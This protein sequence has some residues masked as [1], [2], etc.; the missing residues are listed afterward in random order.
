[1]GTHKVR[2][3]L[4]LCY[5]DAR[6]ICAHG[7]KSNIDQLN[8]IACMG[9]YFVPNNTQSSLMKAMNFITH[10]VCAMSLLPNP[11]C[12]FDGKVVE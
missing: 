2:R 1:M 5:H 11:V 3:V 12:L 8:L 4:P 10:R 6:E 7:I 9:D